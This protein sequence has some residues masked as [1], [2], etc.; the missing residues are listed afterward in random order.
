MKKDYSLLVRRESIVLGVE[1]LIDT[2]MDNISWA[3]EVLD[4]VD[5]LFEGF[6]AGKYSGEV[7]DEA[8]SMMNLD[9]YKKVDL[10]LADPRVME[11]CSPLCP[12]TA[13]AGDIE[14]KEH[15]SLAMIEATAKWRLLTVA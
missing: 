9:Y 11:K 14:E 12:E 5:T 13:F 10:F 2:P 1:D 8:M 3:N 15:F 4:V 6:L 7:V